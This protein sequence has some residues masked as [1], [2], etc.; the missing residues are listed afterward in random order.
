MTRVLLIEDDRWLAELY[1]S[2]LQKEGYVVDVVHHA[3]AAMAVIEKTVP[4]VIVADVL[5]AGSTI[6]PLLHE[7]QSYGDTGAIPVVLCTNLADQFDLEGLK[8]YGVVRI[9][10]KTTIEPADVV[11]SVKAAL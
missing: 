1:A 2:V 4:S 5:L 3:P 7:L 9:I 11:A 10:D 6:F 8:T